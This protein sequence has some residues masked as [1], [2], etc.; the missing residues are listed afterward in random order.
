MSLQ[1][2]VFET[3]ASTDSAIWAKAL[4]RLGLQTYDIGIPFG[5]PG[6][7]SF[8]APPAYSYR[9]ASIGSSFEAFHAG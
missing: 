2:M 7:K 3:I 9:S 6:P 4:S 5:K 1:T 8:S